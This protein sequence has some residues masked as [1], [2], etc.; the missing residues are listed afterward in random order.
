MSDYVI[1][2][3]L[4]QQSFTCQQG[5]FVLKAMENHG[6]HAIAV[7]CRGGGCGVCRVKVIAGS[8]ECARMSKAQVSTEQQQQ[9]YALACRLK[10]TSDLIIECSPSPLAITG[11]TD[12]ATAKPKHTEVIK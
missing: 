2:E 11:I 3:Q 9:G 12:V 10:P 5:E 6:L 8:Y 7:G 4:N 1:T